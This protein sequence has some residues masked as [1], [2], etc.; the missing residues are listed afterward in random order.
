MASGPMSRSAGLLQYTLLSCTI[1]HADFIR[2][3][4]Q[5]FIATSGI[6]LTVSLMK[7]YSSLM[8]E[9]RNEEGGMTQMQISL[10]LQCLF[11]FSLVWTIGGTMTGDSRKK[12]DVFYRNI[13][14]GT[15][16]DHPRPKSFKLGKVCKG[17][18]S[19]G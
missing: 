16:Q 13:I 6:H 4:C 8:D 19:A 17:V 2:H 12:F 9:I 14:S 11:L 5:L 7:L 18:C 1:V 15:D 3:E 10:W